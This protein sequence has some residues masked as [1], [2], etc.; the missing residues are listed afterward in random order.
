LTP[1]LGEMIKML[2]ALK[3]SKIPDKGSY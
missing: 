2:E 1:S 3:S